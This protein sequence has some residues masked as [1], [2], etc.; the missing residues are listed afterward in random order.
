M[1]LRHRSTNSGRIKVQVTI[2][3]LRGEK[4][5]AE[6]AKTFE[7]HPMQATSCKAQLLERC[8]LATGEKAVG[9]ADYAGSG[10]CDRFCSKISVLAGLP[11]MP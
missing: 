1:A 4:T 2:A 3:A 11:M 5:I 8:S 10:L 9:Y 6:I 7:A